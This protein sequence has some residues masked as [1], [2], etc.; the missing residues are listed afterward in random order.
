MFSFTGL[1]SL[2]AQTF[3]KQLY[4][5]WFEEYAR[6]NVK[7]SSGSKRLNYFILYK[8]KNKYV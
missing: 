4:E 5:I 6:D 3:K 1:V 7:G 2:D 8:L